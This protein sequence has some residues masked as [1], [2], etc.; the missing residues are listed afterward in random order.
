MFNMVLSTPVDL[1]G[2]F[3]PQ[4]VLEITLNLRLL[5]MSACFLKYPLKI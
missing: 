2:L 3:K 4:K 1:I 5:L